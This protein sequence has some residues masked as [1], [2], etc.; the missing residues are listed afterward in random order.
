MVLQCLLVYIID[1]NMK[2]HPEMVSIH[3]SDQ[4]KKKKRP[5]GKRKRKKIQE[6]I[7]KSVVE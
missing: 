1:Q 7:G 2:S 5:I 3:F 4:E 6:K